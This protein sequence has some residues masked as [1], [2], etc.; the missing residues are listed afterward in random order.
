MRV[1]LI[2]AGRIECLAVRRALVL[3]GHDVVLARTGQ[4]G[5]RQ[6]VTATPDAVILDLALP[7]LDGVEVCRAIRVARDDLPILILAARDGVEDRVEGLDTGAD[8]YLVKPFSAADLPARLEAIAHRALERFE[9]PT[10]RFTDLALEPGRH[11]VQVAGRPLK[12]TPTEYQLLKLFMLHPG[13]VLRP[14][15]IYECVWSYDLGMTS[16]S[17]PVYVGYLRRKLESGGRPRLI[18]TVRGVGYVLREPQ[19]KP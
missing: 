11:A 9:E 5:L 19:Q 6:A 18:H 10:L 14:Q 7:D 16:N 4:E 13:R 3:A 15:L 1:L 12:L 8:D 17:L 2:E